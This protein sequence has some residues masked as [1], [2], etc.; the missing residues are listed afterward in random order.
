M[1]IAYVDMIGGAAGDMLLAAFLDAGLDRDALERA[2]RG[3]VA[4]GWTL[5]PRRVTKRGIAA[6]YA[7]LVV[8]GEDGDERHHHHDDHHDYAHGSGTRTL[9]DVLAIVERS[10]L[11]PRQRERA[12][13][14]YRRL[15][16]AEAH[17][18]G[19][20]AGAIRFHEV[21]QVDAILDVAAAC[22]ALDLL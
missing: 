8:P 16:D 2:L 22:V 5:A 10:T 7:G 13:A 12:T 20:T 1:R 19:T 14:V 4:G 21:G 17:T 3:V 15:A 6:T 18:H 11:T 9:A